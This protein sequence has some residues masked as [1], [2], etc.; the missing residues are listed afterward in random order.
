MGDEGSVFVSYA[1]VDNRGDRAEDRWLDRILEHL[2][3]TRLACRTSLW[4]D[5]DIELGDNWHEKIQSALHAAKAA[6]LL[7]SPA[8]LRSRYI[9]RYELPLLL[10]KAKTEGITVIPIVIRPC[11]V[12]EVTFKFPDPDS[13]PDEFV[14]ASLQSPTPRVALSGL[15][16]HE[17]DELLSQVASRLLQIVQ[18][19]RRPVPGLESPYR[20]LLAFREQD[21][22]RF[23]GRDRYVVRGLEKIESK[24]F[25]A[26]TGRSGSG[27]SSLVFAGLFPQLRRQNRYTLIDLRP[28]V[29]PFLA[30]GRAL[31]P[32]L[33]QTADDLQVIEKAAQLVTLIQEG[34]LPL[35]LTQIGERTGRQTVLFLDQFEELYTLCTNE[36]RTSFL[37]ALLRP[38]TTY[39]GSNAMT[40]KIIVTLRADF[41]TQALRH[42]MLTELLHDGDI[43]VGPMNRDELST[44]ILG[45]VDRLGEFERGLVDLLLDDVGDEPGN[46]A[47]LQF[48]LELLWERRDGRVMTHEAYR[49][50]GKVAGAI[51]N[52]AETEYRNLT[53]AEKEAARRALLTLV[54]VGREGRDDC[55]RQ[56]RLSEL[57][58]HG[59]GDDEAMVRA[60]HALTDARLLVTGGDEEAGEATVEL[61]HEAVIGNWPRLQVWLSE[62]R[63]FL[64]W[65]QRLKVLCD[66]WRAGGENDL[67]LLRGTLLD[68]ARLW[69][70][71]MSQELTALERD[72]IAVSIA[73]FERGS[74]LKALVSFDVFFMAPPEALLEFR[75]QGVLGILTTKG[76]QTADWAAPGSAPA[77]YR[78]NLAIHRSD[79]KSDKPATGSLPHSDATLLSDLKALFSK[80]LLAGTNSLQSAPARP[81]HVTPSLTEVA[82]ST[83]DL[84]KLQELQMQGQTGSLLRTLEPELDNLEDPQKRLDRALIVFDMKHLRGQYKEAAALIAQELTLYSEEDHLRIPQLT[85][86]RIRKVHHEMFFSPVDRL[87]SEMLDLKNLYPAERD[88]AL[89]GEII[90]M[91]GGNLGTLR[92]LYDEAKVFLLEAIDLGKKIGDVYLVCRSLRKLADFLRHDGDLH[93]AQITWDEAW[94]LSEGLSGNRQRMYLTGCRADLERQLGRFDSAHRLFEETRVAAQQ[95]YAPGWVAHTLLGDAETALCMGD[96]D[97]AA[98][99]LASAS[100]QYKK[101][102]HQWGLVQV[103]LGECRLAKSKNRE[104]WREQ[105]AVA[106]SRAEALG[107]RR[108]AKFARRLLTEESFQPNCLL[109]L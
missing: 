59:E 6:V 67:L 41:Y 82:A 21:A 26:V 77:L 66:E 40:T 64:L 56:V 29:S 93:N 51:A 96:L 36:V 24:T 38:I 104:A 90:C 75:E 15:S 19:F 39:R 8:F 97:A 60:L 72:Y 92:G 13:G 73:Q 91:L 68:E 106:E 9:S 89:Y 54:Q 44:A 76:D 70:A 30:L 81:G 101:L 35:I 12:S 102:D 69:S 62:N 83:D 14:L 17:Q 95:A 63:E 49:R 46:L 25:L 16:K 48:A 18:P 71:K 3:A 5:E 100:L 20:G 108:D 52:R 1:H 22:S 105:C 79:D 43:K 37:N 58:S 107:Y 42:G 57:S 31:V 34:Q 55:R 86:L 103:S 85:K 88:P 53:R 47:L 109:F 7:V 11:T 78:L 33:T 2:E 32:H 27:K 94:K 65:R 45:P 28:T 10:H 87:W 50:I 80:N 84:H 23:F 74:R 99:S 4:S 98:R 61:A